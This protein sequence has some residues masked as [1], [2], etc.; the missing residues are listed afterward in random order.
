MPDLKAIAPDPLI[1]PAPTAAPTDGEDAI[2][3]GKGA[4][5][6]S[7]FYSGTHEALRR[8]QFTGRAD[9]DLHDTTHG[10]AAVAICDIGLM[11]LA[12]IRS[13]GH[14]VELTEMQRPNLLV[15]VVG[16]VSSQNERARFDDPGAPWVLMGR[17]H[18]KTRVCAS[19]RADY[20]AFV[21]SVP[22][23]FLGHRLDDLEAQGGFIGGDPASADD[24]HLAR[25]TLALATQMTLSHDVL[26]TDRVASAWATILAEQINRCLETRTRRGPAKPP[27]DVP[28]LTLSYVRSA[29]AMIYQRPEEVGGIRDL[30][31]HVGV[32]ERTLQ[33][34]FRDVRGATPSQVLS[35]AKLNRARQ[36]L[37]DRD[38]PDSVSEV[39]R[40][41]GIEHHGRF[42][43]QYRDLFG[44]LPVATLNARR[45]R[46]R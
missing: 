30:A 3:S 39:C 18:R 43:R 46:T 16:T 11:N 23:S 22:A 9:L 2:P 25:L 28:E 40:M 44:E 15:R 12:Y 37:T 4:F 10:R 36:A 17:G 21:L 34:A 19:D 38:G 14:D 26:T 41:C 31:D 7:A 35:L 6:R 29:E 32:S 13:T 42:G 5:R 45:A 1:W 20:E 33:K 27:I 8:R 24:M